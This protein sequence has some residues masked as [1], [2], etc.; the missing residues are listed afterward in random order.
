[1]YSLRRFDPEINRRELFALRG[2]GT[3]ALHDRKFEH[4]F[5]SGSYPDL[6]TFL[7]YSDREK[8]AV[9]VASLF[10]RGFE[11]GGREYRAGFNFDISVKPKHRTLG[12]ALMLVKALLKE[13]ERSGYSVLIANP[14]TK[15]SI[16]FKRAGYVLTGRSCRWSKVLRSVN[17]LPEPLRDSPLGK[18]A[19]GAVDICSR[20]FSRETA[21]SFRNLRN[22]R[23]LSGRECGIED[24]FLPGLPGRVKFEGTPGF[25][26]WRYGG[27]YED[28][29]RAY[30]L[31]RGGKPMGAVFYLVRG[32]N[33]AVENI[34]CED[35]YLSDILGGFIAHARKSGLYAVSIPFYGD[36]EFEKLLKGY[37]FF[38]RGEGR[39]VCV[40]P[41]DRTLEDVFTDSGSVKMF[42][43]DLDI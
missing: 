43:G 19:A 25:L 5:G 8:D 17:K 26:R 1:M 2:A 40:Y 32:M 27:F 3:E 35:I 30:H 28:P 33:A 42:N 37:G 11:L 31:E 16:V 41:I 34:L 38:R 23:S 7:L 13:A 22:G 9:G 21:A 20:L 15:S 39:D 24:V 18:P 6:I 10:S 4:M 36:P 29:V 14:N 12:P